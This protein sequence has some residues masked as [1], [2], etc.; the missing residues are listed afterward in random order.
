[1]D[2][3]LKDKVVLVTGASQG[4]GK[5]IAEAFAAEGAKVA[6][7]ARS[8]QELQPWPPKSPNSRR[9]QSKVSPPISS[10]LARF[11]TGRTKS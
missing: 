3:G 6:I 11:S 4:I 2:L 7:A 9:A 5:A 8:A 10:K 1:M